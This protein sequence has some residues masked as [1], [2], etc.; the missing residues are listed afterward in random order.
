MYC[1][2]GEHTWARS[3]AYCPTA[4]V[5]ADHDHVRVLC[6]F[7][8]ADRVGRCGWV[9][10]DAGCPNR[11]IAV[12]SK[13]VLDVGRPGTFDEHGVTPLSIVRL[14]SGRL[15]LYYAGW[16]R[17]VGVRYTLF[18]GAAESND[19]GASFWRISETPLLD[20][21]DGELHMRTG[22]LVVHSGNRWRMWYAGGSEWVGSG[23]NAKP[24][25]SL[26]HVASDD[27]VNWPRTGM[28]CLEPA[29]DELGFGRPCVLQS[30]AQ[31]QMWYS[32]RSLAGGYD[33]G[34]ATST[35]GLRWHRHDSLA[36]VQRGPAGAWDGEM[37]GLSCMLETR[38]DML[39]FYNG[40]GYG[41]TGFGVAIAEGL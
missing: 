3:H 30:D 36:G 35:D 40:N 32:R 9:D 39:L 16:Q 5:R 29:P 27:G 24:R 22:A 37:L 41:A 19:D 2:D 13:P 15:R 28:V 26:R 12:S 14:D 33:L 6:A 25:Y 7:L 20:R 10:V 11:V 23:A 21:A 8:D 34:Y 18:T 31:L 38:S 1:A 4:F 17:A